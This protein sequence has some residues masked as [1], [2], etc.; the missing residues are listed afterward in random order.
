[1]EGYA[2]NNPGKPFGCKERRWGTKK[3]FHQQEKLSQANIRVE[4][5][6]IAMPPTKAHVACQQWELTKNNSGEIAGQEPVARCPKA[7]RQSTDLASNCSRA[8]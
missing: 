5:N 2:P 6:T 3:R 4:T 7:V 1:M 8:S